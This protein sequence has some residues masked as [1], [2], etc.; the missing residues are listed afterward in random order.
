MYIN[1]AVV[2]MP[3]FF[4]KYFTAINDGIFNILEMYEMRW[5]LPKIHFLLPV[6]ISFYTFMAI[7][8]TID[9]YN[10]EVEAEKNIGIVA[11][12]ISFFPLILSGPIERA[13]NMI[14]QFKSDLK[15]NH[16]NFSTGLKLMLWGYFMKLVVADRIAIY[17]DAVYGNLSHHNGDTILLTSLLYP[18]QVYADLGG[19]SLIAIGV[20]KILGL[21][22]MPNFNRPFFATSMAEFW[23]RW[24]M[25]LITWLTDYVY[26]PLAF[27]FRQYRIFG[28]VLALMVTF[29][30]SGIWHGATLNYVVWGLM[31]GTFLS[32]EALINKRKSKIENQYG[33][34]SNFFYLI[35][36]VC[37]TYVLFAVSLVFAYD[38]SFKDALMV[39]DKIIFKRGSLFLDKTT[40]AYAF[41]GVFMLFLSEFRDEYFPKTLLFFNNKVFVIRLVSYLC[42]ALLILWIGVLNG[43]QFIYFKF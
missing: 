40:L 30:L 23:R 28:I 6:G 37:L 35:F 17:V 9:V 42:V 29:A 33:L 3:L 16:T 39:F 34:K 43:G 25:S 19:Y 18:I 31:Q 20:S 8:Y 41:I 22:V 27:S 7:G 21:N 24:H 2:L 15:L 38:A 32:I 4:F 36:S 13:G 11:L 5:F 14:P 26:T 10:E 1:I 12:F